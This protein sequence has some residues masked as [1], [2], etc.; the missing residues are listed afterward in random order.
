MITISATEFKAHC[1][2]MLARVAKCG[3][4]LLITKRGKP[5]A[6]VIPPNGVPPRKFVPGMFAG[7]AEI[8]GDIISPLDVEWEAMK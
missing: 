7:T 5:V 1:A 6:M 2:E 3:E 4:T 8:V